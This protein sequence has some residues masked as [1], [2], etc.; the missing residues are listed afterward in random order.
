MLQRTTKLELPLTLYVFREVEV[1]PDGSENEGPVHFVLNYTQDMATQQ[2]INGLLTIKNPPTEEK[3]A[4]F[5]A[6]VDSSCL[7]C[8][9]PPKKIDVTLIAKCPYEL[10]DKMVEERQLVTLSDMVDLLGWAGAMSAVAT[11]AAT[12]KG[13]KKKDIEAI[14]RVVAAMLSGR[15]EDKINLTKKKHGKPR[16]QR[17]LP[18]DT[19]GDHPKGV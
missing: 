4:D 3:P 8:A 2:V 12:M 9:P 5:T 19:A 15:K 13:I 17:G 18:E 11:K 1:F 16:N 14:D 10:L 7:A 6:T